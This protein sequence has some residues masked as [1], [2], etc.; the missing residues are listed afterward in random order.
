MPRAS[1]AAPSSTS[2][3]PAARRTSGAYGP[4]VT[5]TRASQSFRMY[6]ISAVVRCQLTGT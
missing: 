3:P 6:V 1:A 2:A 5:T 4:A